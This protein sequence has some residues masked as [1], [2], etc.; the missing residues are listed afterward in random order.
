MKRMYIAWVLLLCVALSAC[1]R[2][3]TMTQ[4]EA[5]VHF[6]WDKTQSAEK[7]DT[8]VET[9]A[10]TEGAAPETTA[11][12]ATQPMATVP[13]VTMPD[14]SIPLVT[15][16]MD[17]QD[18]NIYGKSV[19][20]SIPIAN[21]YKDV[22]YSPNGQF[23]K[24]YGAA[25]YDTIVEEYKDSEG[26]L[27][28]RLATGGWTSVYN[29]ILP[30]LDMLFCSGAGAWG[31]TLTIKGNGKFSGNFHDSDM[32]DGGEGYPNGTVYTCGFSGR[33]K[34]TDIETYVV[35]LEMTS[36]TQD[37]KEGKTWIEDGIRYIGAY[38]YGLSGGKKFLLYTP[39]TPVRLLPEGVMEWGSVPSSGTLGCYVLYCPAIGTAFF[40]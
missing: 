36:L 11:P 28:G 12:A 13:I 31:T 26:V 24:H 3:S 20:Y 29:Q 8:K 22:Y 7:V 23:M 10:P 2:K 17:S 30:E 19:N 14:A 5:D 35:H 38:P 39:Q 15:E 37:V 32:G 6:G 25:C 16:P 4:E 1:G 33:V 27:W 34:V 18:T 40:S 9:T 21:P